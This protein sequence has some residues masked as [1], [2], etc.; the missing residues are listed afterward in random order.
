[1]NTVAPKIDI[2]VF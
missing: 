1:M 2:T